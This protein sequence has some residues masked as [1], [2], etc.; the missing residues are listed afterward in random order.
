MFGL[1]RE[2]VSKMCRFSAPPGYVRAR[3]AAKPKLDPLIGVIDAILEALASLDPSP[4]HPPGGKAARIKSTER[5]S[6]AA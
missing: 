3:P 2:T 1:S 5:A 6:L 4:R